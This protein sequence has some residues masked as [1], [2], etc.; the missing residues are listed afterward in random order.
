MQPGDRM[1]SDGVFSTF[2]RAFPPLHGIDVNLSTF[3]QPACELVVADLFTSAVIWVNRVA[4]HSDKTTGTA[5]Q[6]LPPFRDE[7]VTQKSI[8]SA[9]AATWTVIRACPVAHDAVTVLATVARSSAGTRM[10]PAASR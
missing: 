10:S 9:G 7:Q 8:D 5:T 3:R 6:F 1:E 4:H 2:A